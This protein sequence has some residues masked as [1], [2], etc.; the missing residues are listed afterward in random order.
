[1]LAGGSWRRE[2]MS[3]RTLSSICAVSGAILCIPR[4]SMNL[5]GE[6]RKGQSRCGGYVE[7]GWIE[8]GISSACRKRGHS[9][10]QAIWKS[11]L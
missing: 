9:R 8:E 2:V 1:M 4:S 3:Q 7:S 5:I 10:V 6:R 11:V